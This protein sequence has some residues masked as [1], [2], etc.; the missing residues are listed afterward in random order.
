MS[1][2]SQYVES[3]RLNTIIG[4]ISSVEVFGQ[5]II[6]LNEKRLAFELL[7]KRSSIYS[8]RPTMIFGGEMYVCYGVPIWRCCWPFWRCGWDDTLAM[9]HYSSRFRAYRKYIYQTIGTRSAVARHHKLIEIEARR[10]L[11]RMLESPE[12]VLQHIRTYARSLSP[13]TP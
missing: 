7:D 2:S 5:H 12:N 11:L 10:F 13:V 3:T 1:D 6:I 4:P 8:D 9:Q